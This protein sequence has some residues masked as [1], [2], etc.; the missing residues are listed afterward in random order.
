MHH[1]MKMLLA[2]ICALWLIGCNS[3]SD[4]T[5]TQ[6]RTA[7]EEA[8]LLAEM[9]ELDKAYAP[10]LFYTNISSSSLPNNK[11]IDVANAAIATYKSRWQAFREANEAGFATAADYDAIDAFIATA[12]AAYASAQVGDD[13][14][15]AHDAFEAIRDKLAEMRQVDGI[16]DYMMDFL[17][18]VHHKMEYV[19]NAYVAYMASAKDDAAKALLVSTVTEPLA[20]L[21]TA[22]DAHMAHADSHAE[23]LADFFMLSSGKITFITTQRDN[24][25]TAIADAEAALD[26]ALVDDLVDDLALIKPNFVRMFLSISDFVT[27]FRESMIAAERAYIPALYCTNNPPDLEPTCGGQAGTITRVETFQTAMNAHLANYPV[28]GPLNTPGM[29]GWMSYVNGIN[30]AITNAV[31]N[32]NNAADM[33]E[34]KAVAHEDLETARS[35]VYNLRAVYENYD[36]VID[37]LTAYH[38]EFGAT[39]A[40]VV[41]ADIDRVELAALLPELRS[42]F[43]AMKDAIGAMDYAEYGFENLD[44]VNATLDTQEANLSAL[45]ALVA[46]EESLTVDIIDKVM[47]LRGTFVPMFKLFGAF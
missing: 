19:D 1:Y 6:T 39:I 11:V 17:T 40:L 26:A 28:M 42:A 47:K 12:E 44:A 18:D 30:T 24:F 5:T 35:H 32:V 34:I 16:T 43:D 36:F 31:D 22:W 25:G 41:D 37:Y 14:S 9:A 4:T 45:E 46:D 38:R 8:A 33:D 2:V 3:S 21:S 29:I 20:A 23:V 7:A 13:A 10:A 15:V 27:P